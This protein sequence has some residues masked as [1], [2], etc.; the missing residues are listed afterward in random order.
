MRMSASA[1]ANSEPLLVAVLPLQ[2]MRSDESGGE[3]GIA[4]GAK[5]EKASAPS[6]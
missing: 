3:Y 1:P 5:T 4:M 6:K 2:P